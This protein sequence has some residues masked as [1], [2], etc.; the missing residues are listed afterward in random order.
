MLQKGAVRVFAACPAPEF[1]QSSGIYY[2][3][4]YIYNITI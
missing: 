4:N 3:I 2:M 1:Y